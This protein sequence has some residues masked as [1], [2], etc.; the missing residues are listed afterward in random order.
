MFHEI[1][2]FEDV[3]RAIALERTLFQYIEG[4]DG[5][6]IDGEFFYQQALELTLTI[7]QEVIYLDY[8]DSHLY[9][10]RFEAMDEF[11]ELCKEHS[12][13]NRVKFKKD[14]YIIDAENHVLGIIGCSGVEN[15]AW[16]YWIPPE[17]KRKR[18]HRFLI[19]LGCYFYEWVELIQ[20]V[21]EIRE[22][23]ITKVKELKAEL[24]PA[25]KVLV[26]PTP[27]TTVPEERKAA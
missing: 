8:T 2:S 12:R 1:S 11:Y 19:E 18:Q 17:L 14:P 15:A 3:I 16:N 13:R 7:A 27:V 26:L 5:D 6:F 23:F 20:A 22:Y 21:F 25:P 4:Y 10:F 24:Y 9:F